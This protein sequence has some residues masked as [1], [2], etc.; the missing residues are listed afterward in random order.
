M[1]AKK[2]KIGYVVEIATKH[3]FAY[4]QF[5]QY[6][7]MPPRFGALL[8]ILPGFFTQCPNDL[9][10]LVDRKEVFSTFF[11]LQAAVNRDIVHIIGRELVPDHAIKFPL[12]RAGN[13]NPATGMVEQWWLWDGINS[14]RVGALTDEQWDLPI[15]EICN[16]SALIQRIEEGWTPRKAQ[17]F[18]K[19]ARLA[20]KTKKDE[21][22]KPEKNE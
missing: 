6:H 1:A 8:R 7:E 22:G 4:A 12:F 14:W 13:R 16:D 5:Y 19:A 18:Q 21:E 17:D 10:E 2:T 3:G 15:Q 11:P 20:Y 9:K